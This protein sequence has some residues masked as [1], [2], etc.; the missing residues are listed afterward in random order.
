MAQNNYIDFIT[1][2]HPLYAKYYDDWTLAVRSFYGGVS[3]RDGNYLKAYDTDFST[4]SEVINTYDVDDFGNQTAVYK[5]RVE[6][7][8]TSQEADNGLQYASNFYQEK[9]QNV[10]V[11]PYTRL[12][13]SEYNAILFRTPP[14]RS[15]PETPE[16][17]QFVRNVDGEGNSINEFWSM[18]DTYTTVFGVVWV[19]CIKTMNAPYAKLKMHK[20]TDVFNWNY[21]Y[22][23]DGE[24]ELTEIMIKVAE[25]QD[26]E[27]YNYMTPTELHT[28][29]M[30]LSDDDDAYLQIDAPANAEL[31]EDDDGKGFYRIIQNNPLGYIPVRPVY[32]S[33]KIHNGV[34]HTPIF[35]I[36]QI[37]RSVYSDM[38]E[39]YSAV[40]YGTHPVTIVDEETLNRNDHSVG[41]EPGSIIITQT[42]LNGQSSH[43]FEFKSPNLDSITEIKDLA[44]QKIEKMNA[45][46]MVR[47][48]ELIKASRSGVQIEMYDS[49][50]EAF[51]RKKA[52]AME[53]AEYNIWKIWMDWQDQTDQIADVS[54]SY[55]RLY[56]Q[57]GV[58]NE[59]KEMNTLLDAYERYSSVFLTGVETYTPET[60]E[61]QEAA[62]NRARELG[63]TGG[64]HT[65]TR[66]DGVTIYMPFNTHDEYEMRMQMVN[67]VATE[68]APQFKETLKNKIKQR[69]D[70]LI[71]STY[72]SNGL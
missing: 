69:L 55:N 44:N 9:L 35:D 38:G 24:L 49:K 22:T 43:V 1:S 15:L 67:G 33:T 64:F 25:E 45:V 41:A 29:F 19:S 23:A 52:T 54:I 7:V 72:S 5:S 26:F 40:S 48:D 14:Q 37:Q 46:A 63:G 34:G 65:H 59:I 20:P 68:E 12:Y 18:V 8:N 21:M 30:P 58:E 53:Q 56:S 57:K 47:S 4:P 60:F 13:T 16:V 17:D 61:T 71:E 70:Q 3:Y 42:Q 50:L 66:E 6:R 51:I 10:P 11:F 32:Q 39:I 2:T 31:L 36:A 28:I 27:V 62:E